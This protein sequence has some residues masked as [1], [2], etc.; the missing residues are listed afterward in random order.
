VV[1]PSQPSL[2][3]VAVM[4]IGLPA[5]AASA[6]SD[7]APCD[8]ADVQYDVAA[9]LQITNTTMG[10]GDGFHRI[11]PGKMRLRFDNRPGHPRV[12]LMA[13]DMRETFT[14]VSNVLFWH[15]Q[16]RTNLQMSA[17]RAPGSVA[18]GTIDGH[19][20]RWD[21]HAN[22]VHSDG[23]IECDGSM[24][25]KFG[26]PASGTTEVHLGPSTMEL[27]PFQFG[28]EMQTFTMPFAL[29]SESDSPK[30][31]SLLAM[32]GRRVKRVCVSPKEAP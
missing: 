11:G 23:T 17:S 1:Q 13:Y 20:L 2:L 28:A 10:A 9:N 15:T 21:G 4:A 12:H 24:C 27:E 3:L 7:D 14:V 22:D 18:D 31:R 25:G 6:V 26:A 19:T 5:H 30:E 29:I 32:A 8:V 16:V